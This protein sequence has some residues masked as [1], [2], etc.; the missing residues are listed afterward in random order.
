MSNQRSNLYSIGITTNKL[1][2]GGAEK[3]RVLLAN[4]LAN[5]GHSVWL[6][7]LQDL[8]PLQSHIS[9]LVHVSRRPFWKGTAVHHDF[10]ITGTTNTES[11]FALVGRLGIPR[12]TA[13]WITAIHNPMGPGAPT[14]K[15]FSKVALFLCDSLLALD[16]AHA[17]A[18]GKYWKIKVDGFVPNGLDYSWSDEVFKARQLTEIFEFDIGYIGRISK[19]HKGLDLLFAA[20]SSPPADCLTLGIAGSGPDIEDL[21]ELAKELRIDDRIVWLGHQEPAMFLKRIGALALFSRYEGQP[22]VLLEAQAASVPVV[23][24]QT[25]GASA[26]EFV[27]VVNAFDTKHSAAAL[28]VHSKHSVQTKTPSRTPYSVADMTTGYLKHMD[29]VRILERRWWRNVSTSAFIGAGS[30]NRLIHKAK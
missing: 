27:V 3:Q 1:S 2:A 17:A 12:T 7:C 13:T 5:R 11:A 28:T 23:A 4:E 21:K 29:T 15:A 20:L 24:S 18:I 6:Y 8:G 26:N 30:V 25:A 19:D 16:A 22:L 9:D 10:V 14:L